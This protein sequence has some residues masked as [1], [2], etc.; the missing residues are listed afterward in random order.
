MRR[1]WQLLLV[2]ALGSAGCASWDES[3]HSP[4]A[5]R[6]RCLQ[7]AHQSLRGAASQSP[8]DYERMVHEVYLR[9]LDNYGI[10]DAPPTAGS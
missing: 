3:R 8:A 4:E 5:L 6:Y 7:K 10:S 1:A 9:C 2:L